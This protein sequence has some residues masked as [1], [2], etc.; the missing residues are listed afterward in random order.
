MEKCIDC[1]FFNPVDFYLLN[2]SGNQDHLGK[3]CTPW[4]FYPNNRTEGK[5]ILFRENDW[6][7]RWEVAL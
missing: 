7:D 2:S 6:C 1:K 5:T 3:C 4:N